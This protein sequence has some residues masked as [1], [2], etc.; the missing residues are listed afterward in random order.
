MSALD[1]GPLSDVAARVDGG[2]TTL[3]FVRDLR[4]PPRKVWAAL[5]DPGRID[6]W[7]P[8]AAA[9]DLGTLGETTLTMIDGDTRV[10][11]PAIV[12][13]AVQPTLLEYS[14]GEDL[15]R[16]ELEAIDLGTR[17]TLRH[18]LEDGD[19]IAMVAAGWHLCLVV[20]EH[21]LDGRPDGVIRGQDAKDHGWEALRDAYAEKL[22]LR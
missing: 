11:L 15:L 1:P 18:T 17:L 12:R 5:T 16:W 22:G 2:R 10:P 8:F 14:W 21:L 6:Q 7:A 19:M 3:I 20:A 13:R 9:R 4:H